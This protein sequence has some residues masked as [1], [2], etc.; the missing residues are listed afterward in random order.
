MHVREHKEQVGGPGD[1]GRPQEEGRHCRRRGD[2]AATVAAAAC[3]QHQPSELFINMGAMALFTCGDFR[4]QIRTCLLMCHAP[5]GGPLYHLFLLQP[6]RDYALTDLHGFAA[7]DNA[8]PDSHLRLRRLPS[9]AKLA[10][11]ASSTEMSI[12]LWTLWCLQKG[13]SSTNLAETG[14]YFDERG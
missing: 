14:Y 6:K 3:K 12:G 7:G 10:V 8:S 1:E 2:A 4:D 11:F 13:P 9:R 5:T